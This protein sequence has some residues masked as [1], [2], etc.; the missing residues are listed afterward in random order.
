MQV[1][2]ILEKKGNRVTSTKSASTISAVAETLND[3][4]IGALLVREENGGLIGI[5]SERDIVRGLAR[6]GAAAMDMP[7]G[8][9]MTQSVI[10]CSPESS[11]EDI[12][13]Q[14][15]DK[16]IR[17]LPVISNEELIGIISIGDVVKAVLSDLRWM[18]EVLQ[19]QLI[20][21]AGRS[22]DED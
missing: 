10:T 18:N 22:A 3:E 1:S 11:T 20:A 12:M 5:I 16:K 2:D 15:L 19:K 14:M 13:N 6:H 7:V 8:K 17:H 4:K 21:A 9:L